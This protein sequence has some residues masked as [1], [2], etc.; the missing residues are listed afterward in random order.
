MRIIDRLLGRTRA[1]RSDDSL[2]RDRRERE[3]ARDRNRQ[4]QNRL[5]RLVDDAARNAETAILEDYRL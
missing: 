1:P 5:D 2:E 4:L 3:A